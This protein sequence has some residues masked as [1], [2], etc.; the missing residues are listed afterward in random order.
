MH[1]VPQVPQFALS[2]RPSAQYETGAPEPASL[3]SHVSKPEAHVVEQVP[4]EQT[5]PAAHVVPQVPQFALSAMTFVQNSA[6]AS[7]SPQTV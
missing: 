1:V 2:L 6:P 3:P 7:A 5:C 4:L